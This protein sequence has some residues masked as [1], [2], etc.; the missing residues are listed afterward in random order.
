[1]IGAA[2][3][4]IPRPGR[5]MVMRGGGVGADTG[6]RVTSGKAVGVAV[7]GGDSAGALALSGGVVGLIVWSGAGCVTD[8]SSS[9]GRSGRSVRVGDGKPTSKKTMSLDSNDNSS[10]QVPNPIT[11][12]TH[13]HSVVKLSQTFLRL[14]NGVRH[15]ECAQMRNVW[16]HTIEHLVRRSTT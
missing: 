11:A 2:G 15:S 14:D 3:Q 12:S 5:G 10:F 16:L 8:S 9:T 4:F 1:M 13:S 6:W 7:D